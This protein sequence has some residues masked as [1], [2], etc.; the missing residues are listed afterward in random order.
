M[1]VNNVTGFFDQ[2]RLPR[3]NAWTNSDNYV[4]VG[5]W[6]NFSLAEIA[7]RGTG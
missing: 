5:T 2:P 6:P 7:C 3:F 1:T 4:G